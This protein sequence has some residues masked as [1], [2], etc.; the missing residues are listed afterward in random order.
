[1]SRPDVRNLGI[2]AALTLICAAIWFWGLHPARALD[3]GAV[4]EVVMATNRMHQSLWQIGYRPE[5]CKE[6]PNLLPEYTCHLT[7]MASEPIRLAVGRPSRSYYVLGRTP[8]SDPVH[9]LGLKMAD[10][11]HYLIAI[12]SLEEADSG[13]FYGYWAEG[14]TISGNDIRWFRY[15]NP[16]LGSVLQGWRAEQHS[17]Q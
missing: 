7:E 14:E 1:M 4:A 11:T 16:A 9:V 15:T 12:K 6:I 3:R 10:G 2:G 13:E 17:T 8:V 5:D